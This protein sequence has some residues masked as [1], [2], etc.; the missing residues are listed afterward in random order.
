MWLLFPVSPTYQFTADFARANSRISLSL[1]P[2]IRIYMH[3]HKHTT[4]PTASSLMALTQNQKA[5]SIISKK[6]KEG[7][8]EEE[9]EDEE[10]LKRKETMQTE[11]QT[12]MGLSA[13][14]IILSVNDIG[15]RTTGQGVK[16][17][18]NKWDPIICYIVKSHI[19]TLV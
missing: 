4:H 15:D 1:N 9:V 16:L 5:Y 10:D 7:E 14:V 12:Q 3:I 11:N 2:F 17:N 13:L 18:Y 8:E 19:Q 6:I